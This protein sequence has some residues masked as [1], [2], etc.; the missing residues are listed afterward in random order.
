MKII[1]YLFFVCI[2]FYCKSQ[3]LKCDTIN[4][5]NIKYVE[6]EIKSKNAYPLKMYAV[7]DNY[8][9]SMFDYE[10]VDSF[11]K[12]FYKNGMYTPYL[13]KGYTKMVL[14]CV[15]PDQANTYIGKN[16]KVISQVLQ[17]LEKQPAKK[18]KLKTGDIV[19]LKAVII[20]GVFIRVNKNNNAVFTS[21]LEWD[22]S[23]IDE[24]KYALIPLNNIII[25]K[26]ECR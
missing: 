17:L 22:I 15:N 6:F 20:S 16:G 1:Y 8:N 5:K 25:K 24:I 12:S 4:K 7:F 14:N 2:S 10:N 11:V 21:S 9:E 3:S 23:D 26:Q 19:C 18:I 13:E